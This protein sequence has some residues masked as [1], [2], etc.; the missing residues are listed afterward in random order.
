[1]DRMMEHRTR[2]QEMKYTMAL[3]YAWGRKDAAPYGS[4]SGK[5]A[6]TTSALDFAAWYAA[7]SADDGTNLE[8]AWEVFSSLSPQEQRELANAVMTLP[9]VER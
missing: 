5:R 6:M 2:K 8:Q 4:D 7:T 9:Y 1:M 3:G